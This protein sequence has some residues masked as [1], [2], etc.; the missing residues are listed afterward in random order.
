MHSHHIFPLNESALTV[1]FGNFIEQEMNEKIIAL[2][3]YLHDNPPD[4]MIEAVPAYSSITIYYDVVVLRKKDGLTTAFEQMK[5]KM[6]D[7]LQLQIPATAIAGRHT[8]I[9]V[10]YDGPDLAFISAEKNISTEEIITIHT[11]PVYHVY[12]MGF[13]PGF[14]YL[15][16]VDERI[17][18]SRKSQ[19]APVSAGSIGIAGSQTG[20]YSLPSPGGWQIIGRTPLTLFDTDKTEP[21]LLKA[22]DTVQFYSINMH[23]LTNY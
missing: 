18:V 10:C 2:F 20:I 1:G 21:T 5:K 17:R 16:K 9:P 8:R 6:E 23:E 7:I 19:P 11:A 3:H 12:M 4:G 15:G 22:G 13:L 14:P